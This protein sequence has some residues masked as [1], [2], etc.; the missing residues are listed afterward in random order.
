MLFYRY[1]KSV[2][3]TDDRIILMVPTDHA[4]SP[5]N[6]FPGTL[7]AHRDHTKNWVCEDVEIDYKAEDLTADTI[8]NMMRGRYEDNYPL[9]K[10]MQTNADSRIFMYWNGHGGENFFKIQDTELIHSEDLAKVV[11]EMHLKGLYKEMVLLIDTCEALSLFDQITAPDVY[12][13]A[14]SQHDESAL[15]QDTDPDL[16]NHLSD[17][18]SRDFTDFLFSPVGYR[19]KSDFSMADFAKHFD[20]DMI[21]SHLTLVNNS[22]RDEKDVLLSE[23]IPIKDD[24]MGEGIDGRQEGTKFYT[25]DDLL[26]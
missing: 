2:G 9:S 10:R 14:T 11:D 4:C 7:Y 17:N 13:I 1:L 25:W 23:F 20:Y 3:I 19:H 12:L 22:Q 26:E 6:K 24:Y 15:A 21:K 8:L 18:F 16:N 5:K